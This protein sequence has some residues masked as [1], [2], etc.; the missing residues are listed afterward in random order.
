MQVLRY[1][2]EQIALASTAT[3]QGPDM[4][5]LWQLLRLL[6][7]HNGALRP[8]GGSEKDKVPSKAI[9][10][11]PS[12]SELPPPP[13]PPLETL[14]RHALSDNYLWLKAM[15][16]RDLDRLRETAEE[17]RSGRF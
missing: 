14:R 5:L 15:T 6:V 7:Q 2:D 4:Q 12:T 13:P 17:S 8:A 9:A 11:Q 16:L 1:V 10:G 3:L